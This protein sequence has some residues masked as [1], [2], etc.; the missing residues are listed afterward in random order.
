MRVSVSLCAC[1]CECQGLTGWR[2]RLPLDRE[3]GGSCQRRWHHRS[4]VSPP[5]RAQRSAL[6]FPFQS[7]SELHSAATSRLRSAA[8]LSPRKGF[9]SLLVC[10]QGC[11]RCKRSHIYKSDI[12]M[13]VHIYLSSQG[14]RLRALQ[15]LCGDVSI[16]QK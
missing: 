14:E 16:E 11:G 1:T 4:H 3:H 5:P 10:T 9:T 2:A 8:T 13:Y 15:Q 12:R 6:R 7:L